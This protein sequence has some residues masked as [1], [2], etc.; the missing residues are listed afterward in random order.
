MIESQNH[1]TLLPAYS[2]FCM[3]LSISAN[4]VM[5]IGLPVSRGSE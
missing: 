1:L 4:A 5:A 2:A 3:Y